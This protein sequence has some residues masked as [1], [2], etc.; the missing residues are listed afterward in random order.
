MQSPSEWRQIT[1][2][3]LR[4]FLVEA[5]LLS[6]TGFMIIDYTLRHF[7]N[8]GEPYALSIAFFWLAIAP[9]PAFTVHSRERG[10][11]MPVL[12]YVAVS[13]IGSVLF[14]GAWFLLDRV[15]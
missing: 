2:P 4:T 1:T 5:H 8:V 6:V 11:P 7:L 13:L 10:K 15:I 3:E 9:L 14:I 12:R